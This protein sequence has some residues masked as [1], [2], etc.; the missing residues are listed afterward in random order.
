MRPLHDRG[1]ASLTVLAYHRVM[2]AGAADAYPFDLELIS[3]T[4]DEFEWQMSHI[5]REMNPVSLAQVVAHLDGGAPL[6]PNAVAV[7]FD[8]G[9]NDTYRTVFPIVRRH[10]IPLAVFVTTGYVDS[11]EPFWFELA[12]YLMMRVPPGAIAIAESQRALP[13]GA[14]PRERRRSLKHLLAMLKNLPNERRAALIRTWT[15]KFAARIDPTVI[16]L[17]RPLDWNQIAEMAAAGVEFGSHSVTHPNLAQLADEDL[18]WELSESKRVLE[19]RLSREVSL[20]AYP[21]GTRRAYDAR[22]MRSARD[23]G[24]RLAVSYVSGV[25]WQGKVDRF[26]VR[27]HGIGLETSREYFRALTSLPAWIS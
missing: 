5:R 22:V 10:Q 20:L 19:Q 25:N 6:P 11:H 3:T 8:D 1:R 15:E 23:C 27:R 21:I 2:E 13:Y 12:A 14:S 7:T 26:E 4:P 17:S 9:F 18:S 16:E 24:F